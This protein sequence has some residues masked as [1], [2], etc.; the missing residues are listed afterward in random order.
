MNQNLKNVRKLLIVVDLVKGFVVKGNMADP[1]IQ[2][3]VPE[4][5]KMVEQFLSEGNPVIYIKDCHE[6]DCAEF[7]RFPKHCIRGT[8]EAEMV[9]E[10]MPF[11]KEVMFFEKNSTSAMFA[12]GF[13]EKINEM[14]ELEEIVIIGCC[15]DICDLNLAIPLQNYFDEMNKEIKIVIPKN[16]VETY[17]LPNH[18]RDEYNDIAF[19]LL[20]QSG[21]ILVES[22]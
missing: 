11:E 22:Y 7:K 3:I 15:T 14:Q 12:K 1:S 4:S 5:K 13:I 19:K 21:I 8:E 2:R 10:L 16:A 20:A 6:E 9:D 18:L 17:N